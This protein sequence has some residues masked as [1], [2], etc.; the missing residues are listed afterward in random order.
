MPETTRK[1]YECRRCGRI[2]EE[3]WL[4]NTTEQKLYCECHVK[5]AITGKSIRE[6]EVSEIS[7]EKTREEAIIE[8]TT[9]RPPVPP[10]IT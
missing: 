10:S 7:T 4:G 9:K 8:I 6:M 5:L 1:V 3:L 2:I